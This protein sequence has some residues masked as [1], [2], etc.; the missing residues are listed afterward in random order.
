MTTAPQSEGWRW[1]TGYQWRQLGSVG[2]RPGGPA[3]HSIPWLVDRPGRSSSSATLPSLGIGDHVYDDGYVRVGANTAHTGNTEFWGYSNASQYDNVDFNL[4][5]HKTLNNTVS[6]TLAGMSSRAGA[7]W[8]N[9]LE[10]SGVFTSLESPDLYAWVFEHGSASLSLESSYTFAENGTSQFV[11]HLYSVLQHSVKVSKATAEGSLLDVYSVNGVKVP[12]A[13]YAGTFGGSGPQIGNAPNPFLR[14]V[15]PGSGATST[16][17]SS[18][19]ALLYSN[20]VESFHADLHSFSLGPK[21]S[22]DMD[23]VRLGWGLGLAI[24]VAS[25]EADSQERLYLSEK[26]GGARLLQE[27]D[28]HESAT[29]VLAGF[30]L[31]STCQVTL[32]Q[33]AS[34]FLACRYDWSQNLGAGVG[35][36]NFHFDP[37]GWSVL[38]GFSF[39][40]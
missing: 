18:L 38:A 25:W 13:P 19:T 4:S 17:T 15:T 3:Q 36:S 16:S 24:N 32:T 14:V 9:E 1:S 23:R 26:G 21:F 11:G 37:G 6:N 2:W 12:A 35:S 7:G 39:T 8:S 28:M 20:A 33:N 10:G 40:L 27:R 30:C 22:V 31:E 5:L 34:L 29:D